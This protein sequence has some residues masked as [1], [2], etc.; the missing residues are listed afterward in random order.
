MTERTYFD[1]SV[2]EIKDLPDTV[3]SLTIISCPNLYE[4]VYPP[5]LVSLHIRDC[6]LRCLPPFPKTL[7]VLCIE[8]CHMQSLPSLAATSLRIFCCKNTPLTSIPALPSSV[9]VLNIHD[10]TTNI[11][12]NELRDIAIR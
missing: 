3:D 5:T 10:I 1:E 6:P 9:E 2:E 7:R 4:I 12:T 8:D 11:L